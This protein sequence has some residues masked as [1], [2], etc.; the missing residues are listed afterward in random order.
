MVSVLERFIKGSTSQDLFDK[1]IE[2]KVIVMKVSKNKI[3]AAFNER[4]I[5]SFP[6]EHFPRCL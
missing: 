6:R 2:A 4:F 3:T 5:H 1:S